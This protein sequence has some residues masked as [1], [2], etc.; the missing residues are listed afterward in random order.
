MSLHELTKKYMM[1]NKK[2]KLSHINFGQKRKYLIIM[3]T[4]EPHYNQKSWIFH[5]EFELTDNFSLD[6]DTAAILA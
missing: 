3:I 5:K 6:L 4:H 2:K 1:F